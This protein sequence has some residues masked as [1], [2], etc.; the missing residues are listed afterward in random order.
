MASEIII[1]KGGSK[2]AA[3]RGN[4]FSLLVSKKNRFSKKMY[5][6]IQRLECLELK[7]YCDFFYKT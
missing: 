5:N 2:E 6:K 4:Q 7:V 3:P 1:I